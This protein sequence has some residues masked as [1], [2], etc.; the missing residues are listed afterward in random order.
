MISRVNEFPSL[1]LS[2]FG[3]NLGY[4]LDKTKRLKKNTKVQ[5]HTRKKVKSEF[6][7]LRAGIFLKY[8]RYF[9]IY[10]G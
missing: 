6:L 5:P 7:W 2:E 8:L 10:Q 9:N 1:D 3:L 4:M